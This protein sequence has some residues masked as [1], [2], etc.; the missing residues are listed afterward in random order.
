MSEAA[1]NSGIIKKKQG[2]GK[3]V[4]QVI[5]NLTKQ[6]KNRIKWANNKGK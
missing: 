1:L 3:K 4:I 5:M 2:K 6:D